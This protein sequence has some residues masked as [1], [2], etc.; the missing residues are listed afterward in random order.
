M[1]QRPVAILGAVATL[2]LFL[3]TNAK[4][5]ADAV[6]IIHLPHDVEEILTSMSQT[7]ILISY[8]AL[9]IGIGCLA[10]LV[11]SHWWPKPKLAAPANPSNE[12]KQEAPEKPQILP[13]SLKELFDT[14][15]PHLGKKNRPIPITYDN[16]PT[17]NCVMSVHQDFDSGV[18]FISFYIPKCGKVVDVCEYFAHNFRRDY[19]QLSAQIHINIPSP[20]EPMADRSTD[21]TL[22]PRVYL[23]HE[24][25]MDYEARARVTGLF[26]VLGLIAK[27]RGQSYQTEEWK[28]RLLAQTA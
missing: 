18:E 20:G 8:G 12:T 15:F 6:A 4:R 11:I 13:K 26:R 28:N 14:N 1:R 25:E 3:L 27:L 2:G 17:I 24:D 19:D 23:Y 7:P 10:Y 22:S 16:L 9:T 21:L 5:M